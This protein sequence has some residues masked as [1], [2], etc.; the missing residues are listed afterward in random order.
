M[1]AVEFEDVSMIFRS[2]GKETVALEN[3]NVKIREGEIVGIL[4]PNGA[5]K[6]T[7][8]NLI[9]GYY[10]PTK[11]KVKI[12]EKDIEEHPEV[13]KKFVRFPL[14]ITYS[15]RM[16][17]IEALKETAV[18][19]G[20]ENWREHLEELIDIFNLRLELDKQIQKLSSGNRRKAQIVGAL[21]LKPRILLL[22]ETTN[23]LDVNSVIELIEQL[24]EINR[25]FKTTIIFASHIMDH[26]EMLCERVIILKRKILADGNMKELKEKADIKE[27]IRLKFS[28]EVDVK[29]NLPFVE[30]F[31]KVNR[32][33][34]V[35]FCMDV[36][37]AL[38][39]VIKYL[40]QRNLLKYLERIETKRVTLKDI[41]AY[42]TG[43]SK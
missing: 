3:I 14:L 19:F 28:Q 22:D 11:G 29:L 39:N 7:F 24:K 35:V 41:F 33:E 9:L 26:V 20:A 13:V 32:F 23:G 16:K 43:G 37:E 6:T 27:H 36:Q 2:F 15:P 30:D 17:L 42:F 38:V 34:Y 1:Y 12:F 31:E 4:G 18:Y 5:G 40:A 21:L 8:L 25:K 10:L